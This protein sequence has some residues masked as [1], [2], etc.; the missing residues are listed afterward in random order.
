[1]PRI[2]TPASLNFFGEEL[3]VQVNH[4]KMPACENYGVPASQESGTGGSKNQDPNY[5][6]T[7]TNKGTIPSIKCKKCN[8]NPPIK[9][10]EGIVSEFNRITEYL[11][12]IAHQFSCKNETC[13]NHSLSIG[14]YPK[15][16]RKKGYYKTKDNTYFQ[17]KLCNTKILVSEP[18]RIHKNNQLIAGDLFSRLAN[19]SPIMGI[20]R[21][22]GLSSPH[23]YYNTLDFIYR[24]CLSFSAAID[25]SFIDGS[26]KLP[27][28]LNVAVDAQYY[29]LNWK[30]R[31]DRRNLELTSYCSVDIDTRFIFG[32][33]ANYDGRVDAFDINK[34][35]AMRGDLDK[36]EAFRKHAQYWHVSDELRNNRNFV[37]NNGADT[38]K[39]LRESIERMYQDANSREDVED[40]ELHQMDTSYKTPILPKGLQTHMPYLTYA[41][42]IYLQLLFKG[43]G[44]E[45]LQINMD[46]DSMS[47]AAFLAAFKDEIK[48]NKAHAFYV[49]YIKY[50]TVNEREQCKANANKLLKHYMGLTDGDKEQA[51]LKMMADSFKSIEAHGKWSDKWV[52]HPQPTMNEPDK[53]ICWLTENTTTDEDRKLEMYFQSGVAQVDNVFQ[54]TRRLFNAFE[55]PF[56][57]ASSQNCVYHGYSPYVPEMVEKYLA[58]F[59]V[60]NNF[61]QVGKDGKTPA[62]RLG[63]TKKVFS[64]D[65]ILWSGFQIPKKNRARRKGKTL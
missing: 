36:H 45:N 61:I 4:C 2:P 8:E 21:G 15:N 1:M 51:I 11:K 10:N 18:I 34:E 27:K 6:V 30:S 33:H 59:R 65:D 62:I 55:R 14:E 25:R 64:Y 31:L 50:K 60:V 35:S 26:R 29:T 13:S 58:I 37:K 44:V 40:I 52:N 41:H 46:I 22:M 48:A 7:S 17:C 9:S 19:K 43:A 32:I 24:R 49:R 20:L 23:D 57:T 63:I 47:R 28:S 3:S 56:H 54:L 5:K 12:P 16:Y 42:Y 53:A 39:N 38:A